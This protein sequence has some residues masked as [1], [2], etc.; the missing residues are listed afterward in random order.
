MKY[1]RYTEHDA[2]MNCLYTQQETN[3]QVSAG[4]KVRHDEI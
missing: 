1:S 3:T 2:C 4:V